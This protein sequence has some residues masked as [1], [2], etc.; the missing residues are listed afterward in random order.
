MVYSF[1]VGSLY[2]MLYESLG[3]GKNVCFVQVCDIIQYKL[4]R[5]VIHVKVGTS[6][7]TSPVEKRSTSP[8]APN[9][10]HMPR[11]PYGAIL[12]IR[13]VNRTASDHRDFYL[14]CL[15]TFERAK[16]PAH[17]ATAR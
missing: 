16:L 10:V 13:F 14:G 8:I 2:S 7:C 1:L 3:H 12:P 9:S 11:D 5:F 15:R 17:F 6:K 4:Q